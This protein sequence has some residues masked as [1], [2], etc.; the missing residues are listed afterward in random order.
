MTLAGIDSV[1]APTA[2]RRSAWAL[3]AEQL[4]LTALHEITEIVPLAEAP[5]RANAVMAG[6][7]RGRLV[8]DVRA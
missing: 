8:V 3:L 5:E 7:V 6:Q 2:A 4:D 1:Y